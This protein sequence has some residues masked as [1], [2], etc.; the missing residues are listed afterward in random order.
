M[1]VHLAPFMFL[2][3][4]AEKCMFLEGVFPRFLHAFLRFLRKSSKKISVLSQVVFKDLC[5]FSVKITCAHHV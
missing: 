2:S 4:T 1:P 3:S 5:K